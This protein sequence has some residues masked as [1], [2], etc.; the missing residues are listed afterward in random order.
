MLLLIGIRCGTIGHA[1]KRVMHLIEIDLAVDGATTFS[2]V[3]FLTEIIMAIWDSHGF[4]F[5]LP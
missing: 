5:Q 4:N 1:V 3:S 2:R